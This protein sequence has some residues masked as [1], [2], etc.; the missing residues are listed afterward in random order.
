MA[1]LPE[2]V[3]LKTLD[4]LETKGWP[5]LALLAKEWH[6]IVTSTWTGIVPEPKAADQTLS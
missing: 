1:G 6:S 4:L 5:R 3:L 2:D